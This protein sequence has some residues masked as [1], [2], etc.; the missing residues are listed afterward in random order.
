VYSGILW[1]DSN[2]RDVG[3]CEVD[4]KRGSKMRLKG[5]NVAKDLALN[6]SA[7]KTVVYV[8]ET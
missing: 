5:W 8:T 6:M 1:R 2:G 7:W 4:M 3:E